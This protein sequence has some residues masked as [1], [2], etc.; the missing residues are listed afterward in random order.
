V[1]HAA[2]TR[3]RARAWALLVVA[4][5]AVVGLAAPADA[6]PPPLNITGRVVFPAGYTYDPLR[7]PRI[8]PRYSRTS[9]TAGETLF[10]SPYAT[11]RADGTFS[12]LYSPI[13]SSEP[14]TLDRYYLLLGDP[15]QRLVRG[16][17]T[18]G[19]K[20]AP[21]LTTA[22]TVYRETSGVELRPELGVQV[23]GRL[24]IPAGY[25]A[26][27]RLELRAR[28]GGL[29][30]LAE[31]DRSTMRFTAGGFVSGQTLTLEL[32][33]FNDVLFDG[34]LSASGLV[35]NWSAKATTITAPTSG[36]VITTHRRGT[37]SG[38]LRMP[39]GMFDP[40]RLKV[41]AVVS[42][43]GYDHDD[44]YIDDA[45]GAFQLP[46]LSVGREY[47][48]KV[49]HLDDEVLTGFVGPDGTLIP[50]GS[51]TAERKAAFARAA[52]FRPP[53]TVDVP[54]ELSPGVRGTVVA[55]RGFAFDSNWDDDAPHVN[56]YS[57]D[58]ATGAWV[59]TDAYVPWTDARFRFPALTPG[60]EHLVWFEPN[61]HVDENRKRFGR[62]F[63]TGNDSAL[64]TD[65]AKAKRARPNQVRDIV[66]PLATKS[67]T[68]PSI[69]G[70]PALGRK[71]WVDRGAWD[72]KP[73]S[74]SV[75]WLRDGQP[76]SGATANSYTVLKSDLGRKLSVRVTARGPQG[77]TRTSATTAAV[78]VP[79]VRPTV[80]VWVPSGTKAGKKVQVVVK[81]TASGVTSAPLGTVKVRVGSATKNVTLKASHQGRI[82]VTMP[83]QKKGTYDVRAAY[84]P[85]SAAAPFLTSR[86]S[87]TVKVRVT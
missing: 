43:D 79:K 36:V 65:P 55:P 71:L 42:D 22:V 21:S 9:G 48:L 44:E 63:W 16:Y 41:S 62:G 15:Q 32:V 68:R 76:I 12:L 69:T 33:D 74:I 86:T 72:P 39:L 73:A 14:S 30:S 34:W 40:H 38:T 6:A 46:D 77:Y 60:E 27:G 7:P 11:V 87:P 64:T 52:K 28:Y 66:I 3:T 83:A 31:I 84:T 70:T 50:T 57:R 51:T 1:R 58:A 10:G 67:T 85:S 54:L 19:G 78:T 81:V 23:T 37:I 45:G 56:L 8:E 35:E 29:S 75:Q 47:A 2:V 17:L 53:A 59:V 49:E 5:L 24:D 61:A 20:V 25:P 82:S 13:S 4:A 18:E 80:T 26:D